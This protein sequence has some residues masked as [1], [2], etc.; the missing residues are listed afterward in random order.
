MLKYIIIIYMVYI[1]HNYYVYCR[2]N[3]DN[4]YNKNEKYASIQKYNVQEDI[5]TLHYWSWL[6]V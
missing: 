5:H 2:K 4:A 1:I 3:D 6:V